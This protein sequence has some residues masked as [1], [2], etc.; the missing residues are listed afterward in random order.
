MLAVDPT[1]LRRTVPPLLVLS[2]LAAAACNDHPLKEVELS[3]TGETV[4]AVDIAPLRSVDILF[5]IDNSGSMAAEQANLAANLAPL[6]EILEREDISAD[7]RIAVTTT[8]T[9]D[10]ACAGTGPEDGNFVATSCR[11][12]LEQ[13]STLPGFEPAQDARHSACTDLCPE[14]LSDL[15]PRPSAL[16]PG[17]EEA[18][19]PWIESVLGRTNLPQGV[20]A[21]QAFA[22][23]GP[24]GVNGCG[25]ESPLRAMSRALVRADR[26]TEDEFGFMR[27]EAILLVVFVTDEA[28]CST[29]GRAPDALREA[30]S[31]GC[32]DA[33]VSCSRQEDGSLDCVSANLDLEG[34]VVDGE[35]AVLTPVEDFVALLE[36][37]E[38]GKRARSG[39]EDL[40][41]MVSVVAGVPSGY[42]DVP[43]SYSEQ[44]PFA[45][46]YGIDAGC[47]SVYG[48]AVP[49][50]RLLEFADA[51]A[52]DR[53][54][55][56]SS[57]CAESYSPAFEALAN[58]LLDSFEPACTDTCLAAGVDHDCVFT[59]QVPDQGKQ[60]VPTCDRDDGGSPRLPE[61]A[62]VCVDVA[63][64]DER[65]PAC[66]EAGAPAEFRPLYRAGVPRVP[67]ST[68]SAT[69]SVSENEAQD[70][71]WI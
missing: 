41:V 67:G 39:N 43:V 59:Q 54:T 29:Q 37:I 28:D 68:I 52:P 3:R 11:S 30:G 8:D 53:G 69:C 27:D 38:A 62:N 19:R 31:A 33:G 49:P 48:D 22:C 44:T 15:R 2:L 58:R 17:G 4:I 20:S 14:A 35:D 26:T 42:P 6:I 24:Q 55:N 32:W 1:M 13:F 16:E 45:E 25:F 23:M 61:G 46:D 34:S 5:V 60:T 10:G 56:V 51:F 21:A 57:V 63:L 65:A 36:G 47:Q 64:A 66:I 50:V 71:P 7:Y 70:C 18:S 40:S 12:R 9:D